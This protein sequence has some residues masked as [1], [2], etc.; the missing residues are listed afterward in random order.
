MS[1]RL[2]FAGLAAVLLVAWT[3]LP[4][5]PGGASLLTSARASTQEHERLRMRNTFKTPE[6]VVSYYCSRDASGFI[7]SGLLDV[8]RRAFTTW[9]DVPQHDSF[10]IARNYQILNARPASPK[11]DSVTVEVR[12]Q[13]TAM[14][15]AQGTRS[16]APKPYTVTFRLKRL[17][18][19]WKITSPD[20]GEI[21]PVVLESKFFGEGKT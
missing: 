5:L 16:P 7:W 9:T 2:S 12:Y 1:L 18:G 21:A 10:Y 20:F 4:R 14:G 19:V 3:T 17:E 11:G 15:D 8:E 6:E 13:L